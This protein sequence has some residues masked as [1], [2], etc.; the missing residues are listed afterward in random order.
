MVTKHISDQEEMGGEKPQLLSGNMHAD[1]CNQPGQILYYVLVLIPLL[2]LNSPVGMIMS[3]LT[4]K[5]HFWVFCTLIQMAQSLVVIEFSCME[6]R[7]LHVSLEMEVW[8]W[9]NG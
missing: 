4:L 5:S 8:L 6:K 9:K 2:L 7:F 3:G 1:P